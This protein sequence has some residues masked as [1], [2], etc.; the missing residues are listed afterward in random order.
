M[1]ERK[2]RHRAS[3]ERKDRVESE[4][5]GERKGSVK[6][7]KGS[8]KKHKERNKQQQTCWRRKG[9]AREDKQS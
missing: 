1:M 3:T 7:G 9:N 8:T 2:R 4:A 6:N 5:K